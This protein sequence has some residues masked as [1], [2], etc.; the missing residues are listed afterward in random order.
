MKV[1]IQKFIN[2]I[3]YYIEEPFNFIIKINTNIM[4]FDLFR[5]E[6]NLIDDYEICDIDDSWV[7]ECYEVLL[8]QE[9]VYELKKDLLTKY[10]K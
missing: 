3:N 7:R 2:N 8:A 10:I 1:K 6:N 9:Q 5:L 4:T